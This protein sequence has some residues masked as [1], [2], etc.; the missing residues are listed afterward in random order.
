M[1]HSQQHSQSDHKENETNHE[2]GFEVQTYQCLADSKT[3]F[4]HKL[5]TKMEKQNKEEQKGLGVYQEAERIEGKTPDLQAQSEFGNEKTRMK[6]PLGMLY[7]YTRKWKPLIGYFSFA[8]LY[9]DVG[10]IYKVI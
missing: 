7:I 8:S 6:K 9:P 3:G 1:I 2:K 10:E 5:V 4:S